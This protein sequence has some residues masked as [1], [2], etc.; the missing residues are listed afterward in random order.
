MKNFK[1]V[2]CFFT[3]K[4]IE[5]KN[6]LLNTL[7]ILMNNNKMTAKDTYL[8]LLQK[9]DM[10][11][12]EL[13]HRRPLTGPL[14]LKAEDRFQDVRELLHVI[15]KN[16]LTEEINSQDKL[17][18]AQSLANYAMFYNTMKGHDENCRKEVEFLIKDAL[19]LDENN[20]VARELDLDLRLS[21]TKFDQI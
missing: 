6:Y 2:F 12:Q 17:V 7:F 18:I 11:A 19:L 9:I 3:N 15:N 4:N 5:K 10:E 8:L 1:N 20:A 13:F 14:L 21:S 16:I